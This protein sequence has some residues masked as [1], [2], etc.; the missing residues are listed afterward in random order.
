MARGKQL[1]FTLTGK[2][3]LIGDPDTLEWKIE[4]GKGDQWA[5]IETKKENPLLLADVVMTIKPDLVFEPSEPKDPAKE[6]GDTPLKTEGTVN[7]Q[8]LQGGEVIAE[9][10]FTAVLPKQITAEHENRPI[11]IQEGKDGALFAK[12]G[13]WEPVGASAV[14]KLTYHP[15]DVS[16]H[17]LATIEVDHGTIPFESNSTPLQPGFVEVHMPTVTAKFLLEENG[18]PDLIG[19]RKNKATVQSALSCL[20]VGFTWVCGFYKALGRKGAEERLA[21]IGIYEQK[22]LFDDHKKKDSNSVETTVSKLG[23]KVSRL[24]GGKHKFTKE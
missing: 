17:K 12:D 1:N 15:T 5:T 13:D 22:F 19:I 6:L 9:R 21:R 11:S 16:F 3:A 14:L 7:V 18:H 10:E 20:P 23:C 8:V 2:K 4:E 24:T